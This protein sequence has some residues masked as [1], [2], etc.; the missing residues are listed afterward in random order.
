MNKV[1]F[2]IGTNNGNDSFL[3][4][5]KQD[6]PDMIILVEPCNF[7]NEDIKRNYKDIENVHLYNKAMYYTSNEIVTLVI[8]SKNGQYGLRADNGIIYN[9][10]NFSLVPMNDW[11]DID[12]MVKYKASTITFDDICKEQNITNIDFLQIDTEGF[13]S[14]I[15]KMIDLSKYNIEQI[16][17]E[18]WGFDSNC[19]TRYHKNSNELGVNG[20]LSAVNKLSKYGYTIYNINE[21]AD[22]LAIK[23]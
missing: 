14:E 16:Q 3:Q 12:D 17:F 6:K 10:E 20:M 23:Q 5:V 15:I 13:D 21:S 22:Y 2:Q 9:T 18:R 11:G 19:F 1:Y 7:L 4:K 8:P